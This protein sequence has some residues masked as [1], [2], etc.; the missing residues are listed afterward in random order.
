MWLWSTLAL[1]DSMQQSSGWSHQTEK[2]CRTGRLEMWKYGQIECHQ[3]SHRKKLNFCSQSCDLHNLGWCPWAMPL[4]HMFSPPLPSLH[5]NVIENIGGTINKIILHS[6]EKWWDDDWQGLQMMAGRIERREFF[7]SQPLN[8]W[9]FIF[10]ILWCLG[11]DSIGH[12]R[13][14]FAPRGWTILFDGARR[15]PFRDRKSHKDSKIPCVQSK[16]TEGT[17]VQTLNFCQ[18]KYI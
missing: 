5:R 1:L 11:E 15:L 2:G 17:H 16:Q 4:R 6:D 18:I 8:H 10:Q 13:Y 3:S 14:S 12:R 9:S 7:F